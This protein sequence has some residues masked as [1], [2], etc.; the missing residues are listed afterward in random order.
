MLVVEGFAQAPTRGE[1]F[2]RSRVQASLV[3][4]YLIGKFLLTPQTTGVMPLGRES[5]G[6]PNGEKW[7]GVALAVF[8]DSAAK[9]ASK[10]QEN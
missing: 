10:P 7:D 1:E 6:S 8:E 9:K 2:V 5:A 3:L 4:D